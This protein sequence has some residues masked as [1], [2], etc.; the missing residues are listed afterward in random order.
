MKKI[1]YGISI[2]LVFNKCTK[3]TEACFTHSPSTTKAGEA[4]TFN[5]ECSKNPYTLIWDFGDGTT[6][7]KIVSH[8]YTS[9]DTYTVKLTTNKKDGVSF[10]KDRPETSKKIIVQ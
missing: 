7:S 4:I 10:R 3:P 5:A 2:I 1:I 9:N 6:T 8:I